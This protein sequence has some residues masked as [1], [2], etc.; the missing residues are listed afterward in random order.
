MGAIYKYTEYEHKDEI[1]GRKYDEM[2]TK[3]SLNDMRLKMVLLG[4][5]FEQYFMSIHNEL[6]RSVCEEIFMSDPTIIENGTLDDVFEECNSDMNLF[7]SSWDSDQA[8]NPD[9]EDEDG[10]INGG[11]GLI[12]SIY[13]YLDEVHVNAGLPREGNGNLFENSTHSISKETYTGLPYIQI[14][15]CHKIDEQNE[16]MTT[17]T[18]LSSQV[19]NGIGAVAHGHFEFPENIVSGKFSSNAYDDEVNLRQSI[20]PTSSIDLN[21][22]FQRLG[23]F[24]M[25]FI[26]TGE[27]GK[28]YQKIVKVNIINNLQLDLEFSALISSVKPMN[29]QVN[30]WSA[31]P[32]PA[33]YMFARS[34]DV[35]YKTYPVGDSYQ[36]DLEGDYKYSHFMPFANSTFARQDAP[37]KSDILNI[38]WTE[39]I[40]QNIKDAEE[41]Y[42]DC[43]VRSGND[44]E[45]DYDGNYTK[46]PTVGW[47]QIL[48]KKRA[49][50]VY[51]DKNIGFIKNGHHWKSKVFIPELHE[52]KPIKKEVEDCYPIVC[53]P[54]IY[55]NANGETKKVPYSYYVDA[56]LNSRPVWEFYSISKAKTIADNKFNIEQPMLLWEYA[57]E[58]PDGYY[59][60][61]F[62]CNF[63]AD[64]TTGLTYEKLTNFKIKRT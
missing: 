19:F 47:V 37:H 4:G 21:I 24:L 64:S 33:R 42:S 14:V 34:K 60:V 51:I 30:P 18:A 50:H 27:S 3:W 46:E 54:V 32:V 1:L 45:V 61:S 52:L 36:I 59:K 48:P 49:D 29:T 31:V 35:Y 43:Y 44:G 10:D 55:I 17:L 40:L 6:V 12:D 13:L 56:Q 5:F 58:I 26:F 7:D 38:Q 57:D 16:P 28:Q 11:S 41:Y 25:T 8:G 53:T 23:N 20:S 39:D 22:L 15:A 63:N 9:W 2:C 62:K